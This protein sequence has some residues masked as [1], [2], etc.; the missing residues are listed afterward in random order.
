MSPDPPTLGAFGLLTFFPFTYTFKISRLVPKI[1]YIYE[2]RK[3]AFIRALF[4]R[5]INEIQ[6]LIYFLNA[7]YNVIVPLQVTGYRNT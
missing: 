3:L 5:T 1:Y 4:K 6:T 7:I 2:S